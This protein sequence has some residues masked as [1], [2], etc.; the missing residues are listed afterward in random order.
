[1]LSIIRDD[2]HRLFI[3]AGQ[4]TDYGRAPFGVKG[5]AIA[6]LELQHLSVR[7]HLVQKTKALHDPMIEIGQF[8]LGEFVNVD[9]HRLCLP[10]LSLFLTH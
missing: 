3:V 2:G 6:N 5:N 10:I 4:H 7:A 9:L 8:R 1:M